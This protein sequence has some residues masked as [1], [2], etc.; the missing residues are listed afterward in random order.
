MSRGSALRWAAAVGLLAWCGLVVVLWMRPKDTTFSGRIIVTPTTTPSTAP[1]AF[2]AYA[3]SESCRDCHKEAY[4]AWASSHHALAERPVSDQL[5]ASAFS[6]PRTLKTA[7]GETITASPPHLFQIEQAD[8]SK[9]DFT[10]TRVIGH[11]PLRQ[12]LV[13]FP[14]G[15]DQAVQAAFD[16][17]RNEWFDVFGSDARK[18]GDWGHWTGRGMNWNSMCA[19]CHNT[20]LQKNYDAAADSYATSM[21]EVAIGCESCHG[22]MKDHVVWQRSH[23]ATTQYAA[24][25]TKSTKPATRPRDPTI[26][27]MSRD[28]AFDTC[29]SCHSRRGELTSDFVPGTLYHDHYRL[30]I[31]DESD[32]YFPDGQ[33]REEDYEL[34]AFLGSRMHA[35]G[36]RC[37]DCHNPHSAKTVLQGDFLCMRCHQGGMATYPTAPVIKP[38]E[39][40]F[41]KPDSAGARCVNCHMPQT[42]YMQRHARHDHGMTVPDPLLTKQLGIPN[43]CNRCHTDKD[44]DWSIAA[45]DKWYGAKM[46]RY[47]RQR[48]QW[49]AAAKRGDDENG[50]AASLKL[51]ASPFRSAVWRPLVDLLANSKETPYWKAVATGLLARWVGEPAVAGA[52]SAQLAHPDPLVRS[53]AARSLEPL[54][55]SRS[56]VREAVRKLLADPIRAVRIAA[57]WSLRDRIDP[58]S[59]AGKDL[60][61]MLD[62]NSDQPLGQLQTAHFA[63]ARGD[64]PAALAHLATG[65]KWDPSSA[66]MR[67]EYAVVLSSAGKT[68][69]AIAQLEEACRLAPNDSEYVYLLALAY[70]ERG[71]LSKTIEGLEQAVKLNPAHARA[72][73]NLGLALEGTGK[74]TEALAALEHGETADPQ[75]PL[76]PYAKATILARLGRRADAIAAAKRALEIRPGFSDAQGLLNQLGGP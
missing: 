70:N 64:T 32:V 67:Q 33:V 4:E 61:R 63:L 38:A 71:E 72:W 16:P 74:T 27:P 6:P 41:H 2:A 28:L 20:R 69:E 45:V 56:D 39:H 43:A 29:G 13:G 25:T 37:V 60:R 66:A 76:I 44:A 30:S 24:V 50:D 22:P 51:A 65:V 18:P 52:V 42:V 49:I 53:E 54:I 34:A 17:H 8:G 19:A 36:V 21:A 47:T 55:E 3:G 59:P 58:S 48:A 11:D 75:D 1:S 14:G 62:V 68:D 73:Y 26:K 46:Q 35:A 23:P 9:Q 15:R 31:V 57:A 7:G 10:P 12:F 5:E 40:V